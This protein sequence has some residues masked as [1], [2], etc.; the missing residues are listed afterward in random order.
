MHRPAITVLA[1][2]LVAASAIASA[3]TPIN[4]SRALD[5]RGRVEVE[6]VKGRIEVRAWDRPEVKIEGSLG[7]G[8]ERLDIQGD[9]RVLRVQVKYPS[10]N[11][12]MGFALGDS[13]SEPTVL[14]LM[15]P[16]RADLDLSAVSADVLAWGVAPGRLQIE[17]VSGRTTVAAAPDVADINSV[18]GDLDL[19]LNRAKVDIESVSG[20][21]RLSGRLGSE[22][23]VETVSGSVDVRVLDTPV[24]RLE[25]TS[26]SG[27]MRLRTALA[28]R[29][30]MV[31]ES[32]SG[33][34]DL[35]LPRDVSADVRAESFSGRLAAPGA[36]IERPR[37]GPGSN[38]RH[39]YGRGDAEISIETFSGDARLRLD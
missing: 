10:R 6:N 15:V 18:S 4:E 37:H 5:P 27:D 34:I 33:D 20:D 35:S 3:A 25:G 16:V 11:G 17:N 21:V 7:K 24:E 13:Q 38:L 14:R 9:G 28:P 29:G 8:V 2:V 12:V 30:R 32:V 1:A 31:V 39:R 23:T 22:I 26:V 36:R 19:T